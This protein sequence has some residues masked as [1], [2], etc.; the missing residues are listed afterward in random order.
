MSIDISTNKLY[1]RIIIADGLKRE[2]RKD[3]EKS[4]IAFVCS[5]CVDSCIYSKCL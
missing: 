4:F 3:Y 5:D 2:R 1:N